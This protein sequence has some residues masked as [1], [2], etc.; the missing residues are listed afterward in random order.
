MPTAQNCCREKI[1]NAISALKPVDHINIHLA[2]CLFYIFK[3][4]QWKLG[5]CESRAVRLE[6]SFNCADRPLVCGVP[7]WNL[8]SYLQMRENVCRSEEGVA[9]GDAPAGMGALNATTALTLRQKRVPVCLTGWSQRLRN[10][11][12]SQ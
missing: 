3:G 4:H 6:G 7:S 5:S 12:T 8:L 11:E 2:L 1:L 10:S 9:H